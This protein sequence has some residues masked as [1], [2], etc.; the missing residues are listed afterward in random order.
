VAALLLLLAMRFRVEPLAVEGDVISVVAADLDGDGKKDLLAAYTTGLPPYQKRFFAIFW[1]RDGVFAPRPDLT[2]PV[3]EDEACAFDVGA[4]GGGADELLI[5]TPRG[6]LAQSFRGRAAAPPRKLVEQSTLFHQ[7]IPGE[8]PRVNLMNDLGAAVLLVPALG[9]L[10]IW[11]RNASGFEKAA[12]LEIDM[13]VAG[14]GRR[15]ARSA[16]LGPISVRYEFPALHIADADGDGLKDIIA[17]QEDRVAVYSQHAGLSFKPQPEFTRDFAVRTAEDH[18]ERSS[19]ASVLVADL[20]GDGIA[21]LVIRKQ[22]F[23]GITTATSTSYLFFGHKGGGYDKEPAQILKS[24]GVGLLQTQLVDLTGDGHPDLVVPSTSF[25]VFA[26]VRMLTAKTAKVDF[27]VFPFDAK[28]RAFAAEP[29]ADR[30]LKFRLS[31]SGD[32]DLQ[33]VNLSADYTGDGKPD[34]AFGT[35]EKELSI[36]PGLG[37]GEFADDPAEVIPVRSAGALEPVDLDGK[38]RSDIVLYYPQ[39]K[40]HRG[41]IVVLVNQG[42]W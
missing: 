10:G 15:G 36:F 32:S 3:S 13:D 14:S 21:D 1:N 19:N 6:V 11:K 20:D 26:L 38:K 39:T 40:G 17:A 35:A 29:L 12:D 7:P 42:P 28:K 5:V 25:G 27:Q 16:S 9:T 24:E 2:L 41:E 33:A 18:R 4:V 31:L 23:Q 34:L 22:V 30:E 8:L 37:G